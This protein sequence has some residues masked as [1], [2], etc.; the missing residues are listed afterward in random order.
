MSRRLSIL[1][2]VLLVSGLD[3]QQLPDKIRGYKV[4]RE[5]I[6]VNANSQAAEASVKVGAPELVD[7]SLNGLTFELPAEFVA[8]NQSGKIRMV[9]FHDLRVNG[10]EVEAEEYSHPFEFRKSEHLKLPKPVRILVPS[11][12]V[13]K[14]AWQEMTGSKTEWKVTGRVFVFGKFRKFGFYHKRVVPIDLD[15]VI[16]NPVRVE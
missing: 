10:I 11:S 3:A 9:T 7:L 2:F 13:L 8:A 16:K 15:L 14:A 1:F 5:T 12:G 4:Y 6:S